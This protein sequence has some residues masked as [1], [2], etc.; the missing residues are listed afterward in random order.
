[1]KQFNAAYTEAAGARSANPV[2]LCVFHFPSGDCFVSDRT[3]TPEGGPRFEGLVVSWGEITSPGTTPSEFRMPE[4]T[5][6]L[7]NSGGTPF[8]TLIESCIPEGT[9]VELFS[10]FEGIPYSDRQPVGRFVMS[11]PLVYG[12]DH[13]DITLVCSMVRRNRMVGRMISRDSYPEADPD[14]IGKTEN[15]IYGRVEGVLCHA[16]VAG[17]A[18]TLSV[19]IDATQ[20][21]GISLSLSPDE[22]SLP[23]SGTLQIGREKISYTGI[24]GNTLSGV[25]RGVSGTSASPHK[26]GDTAYE[27]RQSYEY[28]VA[29]HPVGSIGD[30]Y[31][32]GVRVESGVT[33]LT[34]AGG[35]AKLVFDDKFTI[36]KSVSLDVD[37]GSHEHAGSVWSGPGTRT[38]ATRWTAS[39]NPGWST[40]EHIG[41]AFKDSA[42]NFF[43]IKANGQD[44]LD[45]ASIHSQTPA[46]GSYDGTILRTQI[47]PLYQDT[48]SA[49]Y[50]APASGSPTSLCDQ[51]WNSFCSI[52]VST[53]YIKTTRSSVVQDNGVIVGAK[54]CG[55]Y[56]NSGSAYG[57]GARTEFDSGPFM[58]QYISGGGP[59]AQ[60]V[61]TTDTLTMNSPCSWQDFNG[62]VLKARF[63]GGSN[64]GSFW[65]HWIEVYYVPY[66]SGASP[67]TGVAL[68]GNSAAD[69]VVG[70]PVTCDV[71]G[72]A[73]DTQGSFTGT[74]G[75]IIENPVDVI[76]HFM[77]SYLGVPSDEFG[78]SFNVARTILAG[79]IPGGYALAGVINRP[80]DGLDFIS[81]LSAQSR[82]RVSHDGLK[83]SV[84]VAD[85]V[86]E[87][88]D[89]IITADMVK[90]GSVKVTRTGRDGV[91]NVL[92]VHYKKDESGPAS[93]YLEVLDSS[94]AYS[95][96]GDPA[97]VAVY[98]TRAPRRPF[99][100]DFVRDLG[101]ATDLRDYI[102][103]RYKDAGRC[104]EFTVFMDNADL[105]QGDFIEFDWNQSGISF[106]GV[107]FEVE[108]V[109]LKPGG[110]PA[111]RL[112]EA[113]VY[114]R[115]VY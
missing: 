92:T 52:Q 28:L 41:K 110:F 97:S 35:I 72:Y 82:L 12:P 48:L 38:A 108:S 93:R 61:R 49:Y 95:S 42:D 27:V 44:Y 113:R 60:T 31:V 111:G 87:L 5:L 71:S 103:T 33:R 37:E 105:E 47:E 21:G 50:N 75:A 51:N 13:V 94:S 77:T 20:T 98:G 107:L 88:P 4:T 84:K 76:R 59:S 43:F 9:E 22:T 6:G 29:G 30:V 114:A 79:L 86:Q 68:K 81:S 34:D 112:D 74:P 62:S 2:T 7:S 96:E 100:L 54:L 56:G 85:A 80:V 23:E 69:F 16:V 18:T 101:T 64:A 73:D 83:V 115:E 57:V 8:T 58:G 104:V 40:G 91:V 53:G 90:A 14:A 36:E 1:M 3:I 46:A 70:G 102:I 67:A 109:R 17:S 25:A 10:W 45:L 11:S 65:E 78:T 24:S 39:Q 19:D 106:S 26:R 55:T 99:A 15:I 32:G 66:S 63:T 89:R